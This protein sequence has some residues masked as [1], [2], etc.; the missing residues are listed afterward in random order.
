MKAD[1][2]V[3]LDYC[4]QLA[5]RVEADW[6]ALPVRCAF[7]HGPYSVPVILESRVS[8][9]WH[10]PQ[11]RDATHPSAFEAIESALKY[12]VPII[13][14]GESGSGKTV[15]MQE[16]ARRLARNIESAQTTGCFAPVCVDL[17]TYRDSSEDSL[18]F[19]QVIGR[20][21]PRAIPDGAPI[22]WFL[23]GLDLLS[24]SGTRTATFFIEGSRRLQGPDNSF[25]FSSTPDGRLL[26]QFGSIEHRVLVRMFPLSREWRAQWAALHLPQS[27]DMLVA[28]ERDDPFQARLLRLPLYFSIAI[29]ML[30]D[31]GSIP[32]SPFGGRAG[33]L[34]SFV[35][36]AL[37]RGAK[38]GLVTSEELETCRMPGRESVDP[39]FWTAVAGGESLTEC[40]C[41]AEGILRR[42]P[43]SAD[44]PACDS[45]ALEKRLAVLRKASLV[46]ENEEERTVRTFHRQLGEHLAAIRVAERLDRTKDDRAYEEEIW[47]C[48]RIERLDDALAQALSILEGKTRGSMKRA[49]GNL[50]ADGC[51]RRDQAD[52]LGKTGDPKAVPILMEFLQDPAAEAQEASARA[53][54][55]LGAREA[56]PALLELL[57]RE[58]IGVHVLE[59]AARA[60]RAIGSK[61][62][63]RTL[64][65]WLDDPDDGVRD[66]AALALAEI[67]DKEAVPALIKCLQRGDYSASA[68]AAWALGDIGDRT[69]IPALIAYTAIPQIE[70]PN[71]CVEALAALKAEEAVPAIIEFMESDLI[72]E[73]SGPA[74]ALEAIGS[75][76]AGPILVDHLMNGDHELRWQ[77]ALALGI[78]GYREAIPDLM[79]CLNDH[80]PEVRSYSAEALGEMRALEALPALLG[81]L[82]DP[83]PSVRSSAVAAFGYFRIREAFNPVIRALDDPHTWV[84]DAAA[85]ALGRMGF[86][87]GL[88]YIRRYLEE[89]CYFHCEGVLWALAEIGGPEETPLLVELLTRNYYKY[90]GDVISALATLGD[91]RAI[92]PILAG[93]SKT[94][95]HTTEDKKFINVI[96][97]RDC[98]FS[99]VVAI[100]VRSRISVFSIARECHR[101]GIPYSDCS[102]LFSSLGR[103]IRRSEYKKRLAE[104]R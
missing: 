59:N 104:V 47:R 78:I 81:C 8:H 66:R 98:F 58:H 31:A 102:I 100:A 16:A 101:Y 36:F 32:A 61:E 22:V 70:L 7:A 51:Y 21:R 38:E 40:A 93:L 74:W 80:D 76:K 12:G 65:G 96:G 87:E 48:F 49:I 72:G 50:S 11:Q 34:H 27:S 92:S 4:T 13:L 90:D 82:E 14:V 26:N 91:E 23:D 56:V 39:L 17:G 33:M 25:V 52:L 2:P 45:E 42:V 15:A 54:G 73:E 3:F 75:P 83:E 85:E 94:V 10:E 5:A 86:R 55:D 88:P 69:A 84:K 57:K 67:G 63:V 28:F 60:L 6:S 53:L 79:E 30:N 35:E 29:E 71:C 46:V 41:W 20:M 99:A 9:P 77:D 97:E 68:S 44:A 95:F 89:H 24:D 64:I 103:R 43:P 18:P 62:A 1:G 37:D 19:E